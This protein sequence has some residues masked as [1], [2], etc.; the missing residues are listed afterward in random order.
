MHGSSTMTIIIMIANMSDNPGI[1]EII[2]KKK[3][4]LNQ[5]KR[6]IKHFEFG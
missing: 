2:Q 3:K 1:V 4:V 6:S 5:N